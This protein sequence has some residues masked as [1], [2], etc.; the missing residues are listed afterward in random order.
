MIMKCQEVGDHM[1]HAVTFEYLVV[2][3]ISPRNGFT[4]IKLQMAH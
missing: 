4:N 1:Y 3:L 2:S